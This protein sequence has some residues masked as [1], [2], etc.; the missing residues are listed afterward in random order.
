MKHSA[1]WASRRAGLGCRVLE[2]RGVYVGHRGSLG[3]RRL[4][5]VVW[6]SASVVDCA[7]SERETRARRGH[8]TPEPAT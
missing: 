8:E 7:A 3:G 4:E 1:S 5:S 6:R 2:G